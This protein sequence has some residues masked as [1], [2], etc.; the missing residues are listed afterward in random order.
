VERQV[1]ALVAR[2]GGALYGATAATAELLL[3]A[4]PTHDSRRVQPGGA[5][6]AISGR[7][8]DG[9]Q[10]AAEAIKRGAVLC[11]AEHDLGLTVPTV[12]VSSAR[13]AL[14][15]AAAWWEGDP[16]ESLVVV[17]VT[18]TD[19]KTTTSTLLAT[20]LTS[21]GL[22]S[23]LLTTAITRVG[24]VQAVVDGSHTTP[25]AP[26][27]QHVLRQI[28]SAGDQAAVV[29]ATSHGL[30]LARVAGMSFAAGIVTNVTEDHLDFHGTID[31]YRA[32]KLRLVDQI[33]GSAAS[34]AAQLEPLLVL[35]IGDATEPLFAAAAAAAGLRVAHFGL[36][37]DGRAVINGQPHT[38]K[39][40]LPGR[41]NLLN[42]AAAL[43]LIDAW[44]FPL[45]VARVAVEAESGP[46]GRTQRI[47]DGQP[48][49]VIIDFAHNGH[50]MR[51]VLEMARGL[52][53]PGGRLLVVAGAA[54]ERDPRRRPEIGAALAAADRIW[55]TEDHPRSESSDLIAAA[56]FTGIQAVLGEAAASVRTQII[57]E[58]RSAIRSALHEA[59]AGDVVLLAGKGHEQTIER[60]GRIE[61]W[62]EV[63]SV[64]EALATLG[65]P[66]TT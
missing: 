31:A 47:V 54:G 17:G 26:E 43:T 42:A 34:K 7:R 46:P 30:E 21:V 65:Y 39:M 6:V 37:P 45:S 1:A 32:A 66:R 33:R 36:L 13:R 24:G 49:S 12:V 57:H 52:C 38:L 55:I 11:I 4:A 60:H 35:P 50:A 58:R 16:A 2:L 59:R 40:N 9:G 61:I 3:R 8:D 64:R 5:F 25:E 19:G 62:D 18:G 41:Y 48:F 10:Y 28:A 51:N 22:R 63:G 14:A 23:G 15:E 44:G 56:I 20:A 53:A 29:E 27:L